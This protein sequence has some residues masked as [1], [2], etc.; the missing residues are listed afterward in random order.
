MAEGGGFCEIHG[1]FDPPHRTC[2]YCALEQER[3]RAYGPPVEG[4]PEGKPAPNRVSPPSGFVRQ[5]V[6]PEIRVKPEV[7]EIAPRPDANPPV[8]PEAL[9][10]EEL[11]TLPLGWLVV[12]E[13]LGRRGEVLTVRPGQTI[14]RDGDVRWNDPRMS[15]Q[16]A[17]LTLEPSAE[18]PDEPPVFHLWPFGPTNPVFVNGQEIRGAT[19]LSENDEVRLG[20]TLFVFKVLMD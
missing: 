18:A 20:D 17:R 1:P 4:R 8:Q 15:R 19:P 11:A 13:P 10:A 5:T 7:T 3:R 9:S 6:E 14:G 2:P 12:K 16:H